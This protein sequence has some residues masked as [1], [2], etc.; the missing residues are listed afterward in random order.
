[1]KFADDHRFLVEPACGAA[2]A[3]VCTTGLIQGA[4]PALAD[5]KSVVVVVCG[6]NG[7]SLELLNGWNA[8]L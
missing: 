3:A 6:G 7:V 8:S 1:M 4:S 5:V 2:L